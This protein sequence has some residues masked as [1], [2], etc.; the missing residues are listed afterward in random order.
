MAADTGQQPQSRGQ[1]TFFGKLPDGRSEADH[2]SRTEEVTRDHL[3]TYVL[4]S[5]ESTEKDADFIGTYELEE[6]GG[7]NR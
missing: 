1:I 6:R 4:G 5:W 7:R 2:R 3:S